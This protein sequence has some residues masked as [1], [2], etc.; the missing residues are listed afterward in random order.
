MRPLQGEILK[1]VFPVM[2]YR[3]QTPPVRL[4][5]ISIPMELKETTLK[6]TL[7]TL[8]VITT[9]TGTMTLALYAITVIQVKH[10]LHLQ[11]WVSA[12]IAMVQVQIKV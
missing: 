1:A 9:E 7:Q 2:T 10:H 6:L 5:A 12:G 11:E 8:C 3:A 4:S